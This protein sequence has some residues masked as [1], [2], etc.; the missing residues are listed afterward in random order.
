MTRQKLERVQ[1]D[2]FYTF[3][4]LYDNKFLEM[5]VVI[6]NLVLHSCC[7]TCETKSWY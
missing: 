6:E 5:P 1:V 2:W 3:T 4:C 7:C